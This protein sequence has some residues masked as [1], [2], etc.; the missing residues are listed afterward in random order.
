MIKLQFILKFVN[1]RER[2]EIINVVH[3][4]FRGALNCIIQSRKGK[5]VAVCT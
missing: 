4:F 1:R 3:S 2:D 5:R